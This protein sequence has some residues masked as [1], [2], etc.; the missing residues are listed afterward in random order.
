MST[1]AAIGHIKEISG[2][3]TVII[4]PM[5]RNLSSSVIQM[6]FLDSYTWD[7][8]KI[9]AIRQATGA[10]S[11]RVGAWGI[12]KSRGA[13]CEKMRMKGKRR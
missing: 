5:Q 12:V 7:N 6:L 1:T 9:C 2:I 10:M 11:A 13:T 8:K 3:C 4:Y